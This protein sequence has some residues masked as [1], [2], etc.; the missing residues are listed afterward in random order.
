M[1]RIDITPDVDIICGPVRETDLIEP[2][3]MVE[4]YAA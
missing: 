2:E 3:K 1:I 4:L